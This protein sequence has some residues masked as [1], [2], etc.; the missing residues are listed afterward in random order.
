V[1]S[2]IIYMVIIIL[3][4]FNCG[5]GGTATDGE[6]AG[7][8]GSWRRARDVYGARASSNGRADGN[9]GGDGAVRSIE[10]GLD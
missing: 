7:N 6:T 10:T 8:V 5:T 1:S 3:V 9:G 4:F 2:G